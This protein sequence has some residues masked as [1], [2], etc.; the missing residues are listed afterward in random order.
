MAAASTD[1]SARTAPFLAHTALVVGSG[2]DDR[3]PVALAAH[4]FRVH[5][6]ADRDVALEYAQGVDAI[7]VDLEPAAGDALELCRLLRAS[8][9][10]YLVVVGERRSEHDVV[11][12]LSVG[13]DDYLPHPVQTLEL[14]ARLRAMLRRPRR[15][16]RG[17][18]ALVRVG[19][20]ELDA[21]AREVRLAGRD[22]ALSSLE[23]DL[24]YA[25]GRNPKLALSRD[26]LLRQVWGPNWFGDDHV[27]DVHISNL[28][29]KLG[30]DPNRPK[31]IRTVRGFGFRMQGVSA[32][33]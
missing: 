32:V 27:I 5:E 26:Q 17:R 7:V 8:T 13:A 23:F 3:V 2:R 11:L 6:A 21:D 25:L 30:D 28:R 24:L 14:V 33:S 12:S 1:W 20:L 29:R 15:I 10:A 16:D 22:I 19:D 9:D 18:Q 4:G 31:Y